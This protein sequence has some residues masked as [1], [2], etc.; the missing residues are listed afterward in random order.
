MTRSKPLP[1]YT[2][3]RSSTLRANNLNIVLERKIKDSIS[4]RMHKRMYRSEQSQKN[5]I[6]III[7]LY[8]YHIFATWNHCCNICFYVLDENILSWGPKILENIFPTKIQRENV[9]S[10]DVNHGV[11]GT[12]SSLKYAMTRLSLW[13][14]RCLVTLSLHRQINLDYLSVICLNEGRFTAHNRDIYDS[15]V[16]ILWKFER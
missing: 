8:I 10:F 5:T 11:S 16:R 15:N 3:H 4:I 2:I 13:V 14:A 1:K 12:N 6:E 7:W 9:C